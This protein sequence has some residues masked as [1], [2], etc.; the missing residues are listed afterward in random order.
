VQNL[1]RITSFSKRCYRK[2]TNFE[3]NKNM[4]TTG[5]T[6][7]TKQKSWAT[8]GQTVTHEEFNAAIQKA[9]EGPFY[10]IEEIKK[11]REECR[12]SK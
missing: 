6:K 9:E 11:M 8:H 2:I 7:E 3:K 12:K 4:R 10:T 5:K 1:K